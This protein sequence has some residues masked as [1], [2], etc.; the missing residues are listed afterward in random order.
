MVVNA[1]NDV[2]SFFFSAGAGLVFAVMF[3]GV[4]PYQIGKVLSRKMKDR[5]E[6]RNAKKAIYEK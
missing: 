4:L 6:V 2:F 5:G 3:F 1:T